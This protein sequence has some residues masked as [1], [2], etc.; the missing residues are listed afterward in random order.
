MTALLA[1]LLVA[2]GGAVTGLPVE[3]ADAD[4]I[5]VVQAQAQVRAQE[6]EAGARPNIVFVM[7]DDMRDDDL[8]AMPLTRHLLGEQGMEFGDAVSPHPLCCPA[9]AQ[10][11]T[12]QYAQNNGVQHNVGPFGGFQALDPTHEISSWFTAAGYRTGFV[13]KFLNGY[14]AEEPRP[15]GWSTWD[16]LVRGVYDY[17]DFAFAD[18]DRRPRRFQDSYVTDVIAQRTNSLVRD[19]AAD[20]EPFLVYSWH[21]APHYRLADGRK[22]MPPAAQRDRKAFARAL[23]PS[24][25]TPAY[26]ERRVTDQPRPFRQRRETSYAEVVREHRARLRSLRAVDR[27]VASLVETL[28]ESGELDNTYIVFTSDNGYSLGEHRFI[29]KNVLTDEALQVP[30]LVRGPDVSRGATSELPVTLVDLPATFAAIAGVEPRWMLD[31][32]SLL[33]ALHGQAGTFRDT[34]LVQTGDDAGDGWA[35]R[36]VRTDR[37]LYGAN[38][39]DVFLYDDLLDPHQL[40]NRADDPAYAEVRAELEARRAQLV[41][42]AGWTCNQQFGLM[43]EPH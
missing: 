39:S 29:G 17:R 30:L 7:T 24:L 4:G 8:A 42:C 34:T 36:G 38:G 22:A 28:R 33:P 27:A 5:R 11:V 2:L 43:P 40:V 14:S 25:R 20:D 12:G 37:Y 21:L 26:N 18:G 32:T 6:A 15:S 9:R 16:A 1:T 19:L 41:T 10:L 3:D 35:Y 31:G 23:P 13:G